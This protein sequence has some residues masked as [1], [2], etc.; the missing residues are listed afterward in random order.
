M[1]LGWFFDILMESCSPTIQGILC[2]LSEPGQKRHSDVYPA[3]PQD[4]QSENWC[5]FQTVGIQE[6]EIKF[7]VLLEGPAH[8]FCP[9]TGTQIQ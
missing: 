2:L 3:Y 8:T 4:L 1:A 6:Q 5:I 7:Q 9:H